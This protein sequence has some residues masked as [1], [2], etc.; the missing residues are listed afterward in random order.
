MFVDLE[1]PLQVPKILD[2]GHIFQVLLRHKVCATPELGPKFREVSA[3]GGVLPTNYRSL[4]SWS[5]YVS[6][7]HISWLVSP[8][9][10][11]I[12]KLHLIFT[13][14]SRFYI[15]GMLTKYISLRL[16]KLANLTKNNHRQKYGLW[17]EN[18]VVSQ[19]RGRS[20]FYALDRTRKKYEPQLPW[21]VS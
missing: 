7:L 18:V 2:L 11:E 13:L 17:W 20:S 9:I 19:G 1:N 3:A 16:W 12:C 14:L 5:N 4:W 6:T 21:K 15:K 8:S 10:D